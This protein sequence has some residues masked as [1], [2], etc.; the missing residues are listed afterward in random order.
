MP[1]EGNGVVSTCETNNARKRL[2]KNDGIQGSL[3]AR[4]SPAGTSTHAT[5][6]EARHS[7]PTFKLPWCSF[8]AI[9]DAPPAPCRPQLII[10][11]GIP[12]NT[13]VVTKQTVLLIHESDKIK[14]LRQ[15]RYIQN[16]VPKLF[17]LRHASTSVLITNA[18]A[19][20]DWYS[21]LLKAIYSM[22]CCDGANS[23]L[24]TH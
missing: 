18:C 23:G 2:G 11:A 20:C 17:V 19:I 7:P 5:S 4:G 9:L 21:C 14:E 13:V 16:R 3:E 12:E 24:A 6:L 10:P 8:G 22:Q 1:L 15:K